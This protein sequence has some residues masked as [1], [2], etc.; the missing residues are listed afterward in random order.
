MSH[1]KKK[2]TCCVELEATLQADAV[3]LLPIKVKRFE[4]SIDLK[5]AVLMQVHLPFCSFPSLVSTISRI[6]YVSIT[7]SPTLY[8]LIPA[9]ALFVILLFLYIPHPNTI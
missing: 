8:D 6:Q 4:E 7:I 3:H 1:K 2:A 9:F 5:G